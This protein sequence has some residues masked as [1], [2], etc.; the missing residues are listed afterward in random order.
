MID[1]EK[2]ILYDFGGLYLNDLK[3]V[4]VS[5]N[6]LTDKQKLGIDKL[7]SQCF[8]DVDAEEA[9]ECFYAESF[10]RV[11]AYSNNEP[12][13]HLRL[14]R[15]NIEFDGRDVILGGIGGV[16][17]AE[18]MREKGI[19]T[20]MMRKGL[21]VLRERKCDVACLNADLSK[22]AY[23][24][25]EKIGFRLMSRKI[26]FEDIHRKIRYD[27]GT[28]FIPVCSKEIYHHLMNSDKTFHYGK[29]YW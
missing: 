21:K 29:G 26:S 2:L 3:I 4:V 27:D 6:E 17:V 5:D 22:N 14:F 25:Y 16:C 23:K 9:E 24:L 18:H 12:V 8:S 10:V 19:A 7:E 20:K 15:R 13:G 1:R 11:L 28:M